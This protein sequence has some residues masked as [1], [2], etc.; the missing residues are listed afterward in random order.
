DVDAAREDDLA[1]RVDPLAGDVGRVLDEADDPAVADHD[2][3]AE[4][5]VLGGDEAAGDDRRAAGGGAVGGVSGWLRASAQ[6]FQTTQRGQW[7]VFWTKKS[8]TL[9]RYANRFAGLISHATGPLCIR[10][11][12]HWSYSCARF[13]WFSAVCVWRNSASAFGSFQAV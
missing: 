10:I 5:P 9:S 8:C 11:F 3:G 12:C 1:R 7:A 13:A 2:V 6:L 4:R